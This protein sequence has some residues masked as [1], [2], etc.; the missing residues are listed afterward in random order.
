MSYHCNNQVVRLRVDLLK[1][2]RD[3]YAELSRLDGCSGQSSIIT[4]INVR[5]SWASGEWLQWL[6]KGGAYFHGET[7]WLRAV[8]IL[9]GCNAHRN[10]NGPADCVCEVDQFLLEAMEGIARVFFGLVV[11]VCSLWE[12]GCYALVK[13]LSQ[14]EDQVASSVSRAQCLWRRVLAFEQE[15]ASGSNDP[16]MHLFE[17]GL[18]WPCGMVYREL[19]GLLAEEKLEAAAAYAWRLH[20]SKFHEKGTQSNTNTPIQPLG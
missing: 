8:G 2:F 1:L 18:L 12:G 17:G 6:E 14:S 7:A 15:M 3:M 19:H 11:R 10:C 9:H 4:A 16:G 5:L 13:M 20:S